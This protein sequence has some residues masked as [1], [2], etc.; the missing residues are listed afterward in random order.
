M[1]SSMVS[2]FVIGTPLLVS[3]AIRLAFSDD[4]L[5]GMLA[6]VRQCTLDGGKRLPHLADLPSLI[7]TAWNISGI[8]VRF[9]TS[10]TSVD[11]EIYYF[12]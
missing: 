2:L 7:R 4:E 1:L 11:L 5:S 10:L 6:L 8:R 9:H 3:A 12:I